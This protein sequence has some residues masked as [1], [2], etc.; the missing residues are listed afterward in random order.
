MQGPGLAVLFLYTESTLDDGGV[1]IMATASCDKPVPYSQLKKSI[2]VLFI[3]QPVLQIVLHRPFCSESCIL[4][5]KNTTF[6]Y[7][8]FASGR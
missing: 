2:S 6:S 8:L 7:S 1:E 4:H 5:S 3:Y